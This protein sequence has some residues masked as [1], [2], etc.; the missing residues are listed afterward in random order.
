MLVGAFAR[1]AAWCAERMGPD[2]SAWSWGALHE[3]ADRDLS[4]DMAVAT[5]LLDGLG[6]E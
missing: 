3:L 2:P 4:P 5:K 1:A 6:R